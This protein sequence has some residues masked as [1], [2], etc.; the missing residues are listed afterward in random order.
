[1]RK[2]KYLF[3]IFVAC[4]FAATA[5]TSKTNN[6]E[7]LEVEKTIDK[8]SQAMVDR[9]GKTLRELT[10]DELTYGHSSG[11]LENKQQFIDQVVNG[12]FDFITLNTEE[13][14]IFISG[15]DTAVARHFFVTDA[16]SEG[17]D[18][19]VKIGNMMILK[20]NNGKWK[21]L[22]RQAYKL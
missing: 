6:T 14:T 3:I 4:G 15:D 12:E 8:L 10:M 18:V 7:I 20:K 19:H 1:M 13:Q 5:Q 17:K 9:D 16:K 21:V 11:T 22:A 2:I